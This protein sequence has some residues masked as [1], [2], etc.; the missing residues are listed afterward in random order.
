MQSHRRNLGFTVA[1]T[2]A[3]LLIGAASEAAPI[4]LNSSNI[5]VS[6]G[7]TM[8]PEP[9]ENLTTAVS[10]ANVIDAPSADEA[11]TTSARPRMVGQRRTLELIF[12]F[13]TEYDL[14]TLHFWNYFSEDFDVDNVAFTFFDRRRR[15]RRNPRRD[16]GTWRCRWQPDFRRGLRPVFPCP[17]SGSSHSLLTGT[18]GEV[19]FN[20]IGF[21][22]ELSTIPTESTG[23]RHPHPVHAWTRR[24]GALQEIASPQVDRVAARASGGSKGQRADDSF[25]SAPSAPDRRSAASSTA[26]T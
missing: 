1:A 22:A 13:G 6:L 3:V 14:T 12:D 17:T 16:A 26:V 2:A 11:R 20:N 9:F 23:T 24:P 25:S 15:E 10:L 18:N 7:P 21:T 4:Y 19:D 5:T 8:A